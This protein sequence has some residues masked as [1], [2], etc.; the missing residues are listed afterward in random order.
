MRNIL[1]QIQIIY[2]VAAQV[3]G[4]IFYHLTAAHALN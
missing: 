1:A 2:T 4:R 3:C